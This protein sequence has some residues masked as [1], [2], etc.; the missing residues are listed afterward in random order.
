MHALAL[1]LVLA[2]Q[3][4]PAASAPGWDTFSDPGL[5]IEL[6]RP[7][8]WAVEALPNDTV[9][10]RATPPLGGMVTLIP[11]QAAVPPRALL[12]DFAARLNAAILKEQATSNG[13]AALIRYS[14]GN[15]AGGRT[16]LLQ[17]AA[18][19]TRAI[20][21]A[22]SAPDAEFAPARPALTSIAASLKLT[23][24][25][26]PAA[27]SDVAT[28]AQKPLL[29]EPF[30]EPKD[31][32]FSGEL[33]GDWQ[34]ELEVAIVP[35]PAPYVR[36]SAVGKSGDN[37]FAFVHYKLASFQVPVPN[38]TPAHPGFRYY[39]AGAWALERY[40]FPSVVK[41]SPEEFGDWKIRRKGGVQVLFYHPSNVR[42]DGEEVEYSYRYKGELLNGRVY[43]VT[44]HLPSD[45]SPVWF[46]YGLFGYEAPEGREANARQAALQLLKSFTFE[47]RYAPQADMFWKLASQAGLRAL[48][49]DAPKLK[50]DATVRRGPLT[51]LEQAAAALAELKDAAGMPAPVKISLSDF[52]TG[53]GAAPAL[54]LRETEALK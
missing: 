29:F 21:L 49:A 18:T 10:V 22:L 4:T 23:P 37:L 39:E 11:V 50:G 53:P 5:G 38:L 7:T 40:L 9:V 32:A 14:D 1:A 12:L 25:P 6:T 17:V 34:K 13:Y 28:V 26:P 42:F 51:R 19:P 41:R 20:L 47:G 52:L 15:P 54:T 8:G 3:L 33:P 31:Q 45:P 16:A 24:Q 46:I 48:T 44:Y 27:P 35:G 2:A 43:V 30:R 36:A